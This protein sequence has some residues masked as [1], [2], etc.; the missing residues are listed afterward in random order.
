MTFAPWNLA[1]PKSFMYIRKKGT[2]GM[3][4]NDGEDML[5][6]GEYLRHY[7]RAQFCWFDIQAV[8]PPLST[9]WAKE[10]CVLHNIGHVHHQVTIGAGEVSE[11]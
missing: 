11:S 9:L 7:Y 5:C 1:L 10:E 2:Y 3:G 8:L 4:G 6:K